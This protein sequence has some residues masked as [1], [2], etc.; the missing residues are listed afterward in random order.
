MS[1]LPGWLTLGIAR[2]GLRGAVAKK[3]GAPAPARAAPVEADKAAG[4][5]T[6]S[7]WLGRWSDALRKLAIAVVVV[8][9]GL[10]AIYTV[11]RA[12]MRPALVVEPVAIQAGKSEDAPTPDIVAQSIGFH[13]W[14]IQAD[15]VADW[16]QLQVSDA[17]DTGIDIEIPGAPLS[18]GGA[19]REI[20]KLIGVRRT[21][22]RVSIVRAPS[23]G[24]LAAHVS[25]TGDPAA[26]ALCP[27]PDKPAIGSLD[28]LYACVADTAMTFIDPKVSAML[29][30][31]Q[32][33]RDCTGLRRAPPGESGGD[34]LERID[35]W[36]ARCGFPR[37]EQLLA[38]T[39]R[40]AV[41]GD[42]PWISY[43][44]GQIH[45]ARAQA[46]KGVDIEHQIAQLEEAIA[47]FNDAARLAPESSTVIA[48][49][50]EAHLN[51]AVFLHEN[52]RVGGGVVLSDAAR[53]GYLSQVEGALDAAVAVLPDQLIFRAPDLAGKIYELRG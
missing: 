35:E 4:V 36:R 14:K 3:A 15:G 44:H 21:V 47:H 40:R 43:M 48:A 10:I 7:D 5:E 37:T 9:S 33:G 24:S 23:G 13:L 8:P 53:R 28:A 12:A 34:A 38:R 31:R 27:P 41:A 11:G 6:W 50:G 25:V 30:L 17:R 2:A 19:L 32:E 29:A 26:R 42:Q 18:L 22:I 45:F 52:I 39:A 51:K 49:L 16:R 1:K 20:A 46:F